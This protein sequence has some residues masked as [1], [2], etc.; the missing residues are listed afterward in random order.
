MQIQPVY[1]QLLDGL[2]PLS[3]LV[4][5]VHCLQ[6]PNSAETP[7]PHVQLRLPASQGWDAFE[8]GRPQGKLKTRALLGMLL[9]LGFLRR[10]RKT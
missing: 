4:L 6:K 1:L 10:S 7:V 5:K 8:V 3:D 9:L 2:L